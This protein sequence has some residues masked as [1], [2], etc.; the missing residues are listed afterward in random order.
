MA[1][2]YKN[3]SR[4]TDYHH[5]IDAYEENRATKCTFIDYLEI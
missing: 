4:E 1:L 5:D 3:L 2:L